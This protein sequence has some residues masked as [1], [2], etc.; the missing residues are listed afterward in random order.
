MPLGVAVGKAEVGEA[1]TLVPA[2]PEAVGEACAA[3]VAVRSMVGRA[4]GWARG[5]ASAWRG[6]W[7]RLSAQA[8][9]MAPHPSP[10][11]RNVNLRRSRTIRIAVIP[12]GP[13]GRATLDGKSSGRRAS[14]S[15]VLSPST[16]KPCCSDRLLVSLLSSTAP[17][18][19]PKLKLSTYI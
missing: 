11:Q 4:E 19:T 9:S 3:A 16:L 13:Y 6:P 15:S 7:T 5:P 12:M 18:A 8:S 1:A 10:N 2:P 14:K 17:V